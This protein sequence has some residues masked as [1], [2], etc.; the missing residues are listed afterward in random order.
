MLTGG[1]IGPAKEPAKEQLA[2]APSRGEGK[3]EFPA[4]NIEI[5]G[6]IGYVWK[7]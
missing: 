5:T 7:M 4:E 3:S 2:I 6:K 1:D